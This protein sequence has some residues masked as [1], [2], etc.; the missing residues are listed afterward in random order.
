MRHNGIPEDLIQFNYEPLLAMAYNPRNFQIVWGE[1]Q[2]HL[3]FRWLT[4]RARDRAP[5]PARGPFFC[6]R[7]PP[8]RDQTG[9]D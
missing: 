1:T 2:V 4:S 8:K 3:F 6:Q 5:L 9:L 7:H